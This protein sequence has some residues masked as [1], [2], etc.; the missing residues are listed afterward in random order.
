VEPAKR[1]HVAQLGID[2]PRRYFNAGVLVMDLSLMRDQHSLEEIMSCVATRRDEFSW[3]DQDALNIVF[4]D[5]W[6][7]L[8]PRWNAQNSF[9]LWQ[10]WAQ[11]VF[12]DHALREAVASP[13]IVHFEGPS[14][15]KPWH[16]LSQH[17]FRDQYRQALAGTPWRD[18]PL[19]ERTTATRLIHRLPQS[20]WLPAYVRLLKA[21]AR[22]EAG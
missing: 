18:E 15:V 6:Y 19:L 21:K 9:W 17:A 22:R 1:V 2:D 8:H 11:E 10:E 20:L 16:Y 3:F 12:G 7:P 4:A 5:R 13:A 14:F